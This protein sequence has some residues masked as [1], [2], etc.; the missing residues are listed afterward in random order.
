[1]SRK[2]LAITAP[3]LLLV[4]AALATRPLL[5]AL[6]VVAN[7]V[8]AALYTWR[9]KSPE[10]ELDRLFWAVTLRPL[11][12]LSP[13]DRKRRI[14]ELACVRLHHPLLGPTLFPARAMEQKLVQVGSASLDRL[15][16]RNLLAYREVLE[17]RGRS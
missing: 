10:R 15:L 13:A 6:I 1:M 12:A 17:L 2:L 11:A 3:L 4:S 9:A 8:A 14:A 16:G 5:L 7:L